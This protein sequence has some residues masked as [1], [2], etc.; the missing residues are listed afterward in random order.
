MRCI[1]SRVLFHYLRRRES[2]VL[3]KQKLQN[4]ASVTNNSNRYWL[5]H[6]LNRTYAVFPESIDWSFGLVQA[7]LPPL[8]VKY[9]QLNWA[10][11]GFA[12]ISPIVK[13]FSQ[14]SSNIDKFGEDAFF[15]LNAHKKGT[16]F[17]RSKSV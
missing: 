3:G 15:T 13:C 4:A 5:T 7:P 11:A 16:Y 10:A 8:V 9:V 2:I 17:N 12:K 14:S 6:L 1:F